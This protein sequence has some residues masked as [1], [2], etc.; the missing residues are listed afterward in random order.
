M[1]GHPGGSTP[2]TSETREIPSRQ[3]PNPADE[4]SWLDV[5]AVGEFLTGDQDPGAD[6]GL[7]TDNVLQYVQASR[8]ASVSWNDIG[9]PEDNELNRFF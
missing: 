6:L 4:F 5:Q 9:W 3:N 7:G 8:Q 1:V 2:A